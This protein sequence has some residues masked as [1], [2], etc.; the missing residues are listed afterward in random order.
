M[1]LTCL[2]TSSTV[3]ETIKLNQNTELIGLDGNPLNG[4]VL[5]SWNQLVYTYRSTGV[6]LTYFLSSYDS[7]T[8]TM[9]NASS[10]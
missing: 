8:Q 5:D 10:T 7:S 4:F 6:G 2:E 9:S 3:I 1:T